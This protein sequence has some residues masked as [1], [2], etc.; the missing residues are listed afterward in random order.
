MSK[1]RGSYFGNSRNSS[2]IVMTQAQLAKLKSDIR[3]EVVDKISKFDVEVMLTCFAWVL[4]KN[5]KWG[6]KRI[7]R[8]LA[9]VDEVFG[10]VLDGEWSDVDMRD[11]LKE[12]T[13]I[14]IRCDGGEDGTE[15]R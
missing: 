2:T 7:F 15:I 3:K 10:L 4:R 12:E 8:T 9:S 14:V 13:G 6:Y 11:Q 1:G 5:Y